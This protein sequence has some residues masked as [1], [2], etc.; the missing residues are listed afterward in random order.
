MLF[1]SLGH[2]ATVMDV[3]R[4]DIPT[5]SAIYRKKY[6]NAINADNLASGVD[7][8][9]F[10]IAVNSGVG[11]ALQWLQEC[12]HLSPSARV[13]YLDNRRRNFYRALKTFWRFGNGWMERERAMYSHA[14]TLLET[15]H[16]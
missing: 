4:L 12:A 16:V 14:R 13:D 11:R 6:W 2:R 9:A 5:A 7:T 15:Q 10:D 3:K 1:R 8:L